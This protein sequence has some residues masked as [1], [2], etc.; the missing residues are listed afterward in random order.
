M[1]MSS[2]T[3]INSGEILR[4]YIMHMQKVVLY[5]IFLTKKTAFRYSVAT[6]P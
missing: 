5:L 1:Q 4:R 3:D 2:D 6:F